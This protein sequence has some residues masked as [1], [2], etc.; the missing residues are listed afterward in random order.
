MV[1]S[2]SLFLAT[3]VARKRGGYPLSS[4]AML[5]FLQPT[6][7]IAI[8]IALSV[9]EWAH[10]FVAYRLGDPTAKNEGRVT[11]NPIAHLD[12]VGTI[13]FILVGF[14]WGKPVPVNPMYFSHYK[15]DSALVAAAGPASNFVLATGAFILITML[16][17]QTI[18]GS[19]LQQFASQLLHDILTINL[20]LMA[21]NLLPVAPLD[22]S[23]VIHLFI[24]LNYEEQYQ[25]FMSKGP[26]ILLALIVLGRATSVDIL[27]YWIS[28]I[29]E[30]IFRIMDAISRLL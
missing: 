24:P 28:F 3:S 13:L 27:S 2:C 23:K 4:L 21:F 9:H 19:I 29:I 17:L 22:G 10:A 7:I 30:P 15:R 1:L 8:L 20:V 25:E 18:G 14:G 26:W 12:P 16:G 11:L 6:F 5:D